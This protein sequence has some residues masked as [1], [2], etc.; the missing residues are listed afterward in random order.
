MGNRAVASMHCHFSLVSLFIRGTLGDLWSS[1]HNCKFSVCSLI[2][3]LALNELLRHPPAVPSR[4]KARADHILLFLNP[5]H[6]EAE[7]AISLFPVPRWVKD[8][9]VGSNSIFLFLFLWRSHHFTI[10]LRLLIVISSNLLIEFLRVTCLIDK[11]C[12]LHWVHFK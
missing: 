3:N 9:L 4:E 5:V 12:P 7:F 6:M 8:S 1:L 2:F 10:F 11:G